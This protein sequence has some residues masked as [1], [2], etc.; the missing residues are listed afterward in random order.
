[1]KEESLQGLHLHP[2][3][4]CIF[5]KPQLKVK[6]MLEREAVFGFECITICVIGANLEWH[7]E[8]NG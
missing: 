5:L 1:M 2:S 3:F 8:V 6:I 4:G 7:L